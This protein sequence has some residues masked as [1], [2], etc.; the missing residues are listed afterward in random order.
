L[1]T[2]T[3]TG[4][5]TSVAGRSAR[6]TFAVPTTDPPAEVTAPDG[7]AWRTTGG[8]LR[9]IARRVLPFV[10]RA[11]TRYYTLGG[12]AIFREDDCAE[13]LTAVATDGYRPSVATLVCIA[14][15]EPW[16]PDHACGNVI[17]PD[18]FQLAVNLAGEDDEV[19]LIW[20][21]RRDP[22]GRPTVSEGI[23]IVTPNGVATALP[24]EGRYPTWRDALPGGEP[25]AVL[26]INDLTPLR[27][28]IAALRSLESGEQKEINLEWAN[29]IDPVVWSTVSESG[30]G[31]ICV[32]ALTGI[33]GPVA[34]CLHAAHLA[35]ALSAFAGDGPVRLEFRGPK[36]AVVLRGDQLLHVLSPI[37]AGAAESP[38]FL[39][40]TPE[41]VA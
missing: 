19:R 28:A 1:L 31:T 34:T 6:W 23:T 39:G 26:S 3:V 24:V 40:A 30:D 9:A 33:G 11:N 13:G 10:A 8:S 15:G 20:T 38:R 16:L 4:E 36:T 32:P 29:G 25:A 21:A 22:S 14:E 5:R 17:P 12:V 27:D 35:E 41:A 18:L 2:V 7:P 37:S